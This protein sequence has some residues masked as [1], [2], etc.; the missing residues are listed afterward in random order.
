MLKW[1]K[2]NFF[3]YLPSNTT[4]YNDTDNKILL[5]NNTN[6]IN[7]RTNVVRLAITNVDALYFYLLPYLVSPKF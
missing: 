4:I 6:T 5:I 7:I 2:K 3:L 1:H